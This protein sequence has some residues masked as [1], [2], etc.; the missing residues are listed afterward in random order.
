[1]G[2][3]VLPERNFVV[4]LYSKKRTLDATKNQIEA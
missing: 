4:A 2:G 1:M 3:G